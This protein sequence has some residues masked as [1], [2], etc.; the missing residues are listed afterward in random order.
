MDYQNLLMQPVPVMHEARQQ[1]RGYRQYSIDTNHVQY[2]EDLV[3]VR[4]YGLAG[5]AYYSRPNAATG[6]T[7]TD[8]SK[9]LY[10]RKTVA[11]KLQKINKHLNAPEITKFFGGTVEL[12][13]E[14]AHRSYE[15]QHHLRT[16]VF[17]ELIRVQNPSISE[18]ALRKKLD[19]LIAAPTRDDK[20]PS[21][22]ASGGAVDVV[23]RYKQ[24]TLDFM[25]DT[26][27]FFGNG[28]ADTSEIV[29]PDYYE[30]HTVKDR[31]MQKAQANRRAFY[32]IMTG[33]V[34]NEQ[35]GLLVN[36]TEWWH[37]SYGDQ[38]WAKLS[39]VPA[40]LYGFAD[41]NGGV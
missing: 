26:K 23:L 4:D 25:A 38:M 18:K 31:D 15:L 29:F 5:Q 12:Y 8:V 41:L 3:A 33:T 19:D 13:I 7:V 36:P 14:D 28:D 21:P 30:N 9:E 40:A 39:G 35:T 37:W 22:H 1:K 6:T 34:F 17:P 24:D 10:V 20:S 27:I 32:A 11:E 2:T 16:K